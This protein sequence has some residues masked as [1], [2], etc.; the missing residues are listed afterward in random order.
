MERIS[1]YATA[2]SF[3][4]VILTWFVFAGTFLLRKKPAGAK[5]ATRA[6]KSLIGIALQGLSFGLIWTFRRSPFLS[7]FVDDRFVLNVI[8][9]I[10][11]I[12]LAL[13]SVWMAN[14]AIR[15]LGKQWS[16]EARLIEDHKLITSGVYQIVRH[17]IYAAMFGM[18]IA[19]ALTLSHWLITIIAVV[20]FLA[21]TKVRT[22]SE[23]KLLRDAFPE[24]YKNY[25]AQVAGFI[26]FVRFF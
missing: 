26:P 11:A 2:I 10:L 9:Q 23:E 15:E 8:F 6:P 22:F 3:G 14:S 24:D 4:I 12:F 19:T 21:G 1:F 7:P 5:D 18:L 13:G 16:L 17:P 20:V 25:A